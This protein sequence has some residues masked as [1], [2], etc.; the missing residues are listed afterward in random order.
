LKFLENEDYGATHKTRA[1]D[2][3]LLRGVREG[4][5]E[6]R[7]FVIELREMQTALESGKDFSN[8]AKKN[9]K[10]FPENE[11]YEVIAQTGN[12]LKGGRPYT[13]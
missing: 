2:A 3:S 4:A 1:R 8:W 13:T 7:S 12:N 9:L 5:E 11:D 10:K 6:S